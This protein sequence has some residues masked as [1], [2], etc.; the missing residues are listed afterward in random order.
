[1]SPVPPD[2]PSSREDAYA[3]TDPGGHAPT[4]Q[5]TRGPTSAP[6]DPLVL[7]EVGYDLGEVIGRG[8]MG[9]VLTA[10]DRRIGR[11]VAIKRMHGGAPSEQAI[12]RFL[13]EARIQARLDHPAIVPVHE[14]GIDAS[15]LPYFT[16]KRLAGETL[17]QR[18]TATASQ[19]A[20]QPLLRAFVDV[21]LAVEFAHSR[22]VVHRDLKPSNIMLGDYGEVY[23]LDWGIAR[24]LTDRRRSPTQSTDI[25][26][27]DQGTKTGDLLGTP[28]FM[29][30]EQV[31][32]L[33]AGPASDVYALGSILFEILAG[34][35]LHRRGTAAIA[36]TLSSPQQAPAKRVPARDIA[37]ELDA[38]CY[39]AL[40]EDPELRPTARALAD[41]VQR[42]LD[43]DRD[44]EA[45]RRVAAEQLALAQA[46]VDS[47][48]PEARATAIHCAGRALALDPASTEAARLVTALIVEPPRVLPAELVTA[49]AEED[50]RAGTQRLR[51]SV[52]SLLAMSAIVLVLPLMHIRNWTTLAIIVSALVA[53]TAVLWRAHVHRRPHPAMSL[54]AGSVLAIAFTRVLGPFVL[55]PIVIAGSLLA[56]TA[57]PW[58]QKRPLIVAGWLVAVILVPQVLEWTGVFAETWSTGDGGMCV[59]SAILIGKSRGDALE[60]MFTNLVLLGAVAGYAIQVS[61]N[62]TRA[63]HKLYVQAWHLGHLLPAEVVT[64]PGTS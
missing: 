31:R 20:L 14:L 32:G 36:S 45:R 28:G 52:F 26:T 18:L 7:P 2:V 57:N 34:E 30:P 50:R 6:V 17:A 55:T 27:L 47:G 56:I 1:M 40:A 61:R 44:L 49:L 5:D 15:G 3:T 19:G 9:E 58:L 8:G 39:A 42:Y 48:N 60:V 12:T 54:I 35:S 24:V 22:G 4:S 38:V 53:T 62:A 23:V 59:T 11:E 10:H 29:A 21:C 37:P 25:D 13:R 46:A 63:S 16:M 64:G 51:L 41:G 33:E 43:G